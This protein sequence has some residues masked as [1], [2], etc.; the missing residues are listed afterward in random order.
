MQ[1]LVILRVWRGWPGS[2]FSA[3]RTEEESWSLAS[4]GS[5][6]HTNSAMQRNTRDWHKVYAQVSKYIFSLFYR[7][8]HISP[9]RITSQTMLTCLTRIIPQS[10]QSF[11]ILMLHTN[12][13][14]LIST[15]QAPGEP[16][17]PERVFWIFKAEANQ[18]NKHLL[19]LFLGLHD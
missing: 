9:K 12:H 7:K 14:S 15:C 2:P 3:S 16:T 11:S 6:T 10:T 1:M 5:K 4:N 13:S 8:S 17:R 19:S 18:T